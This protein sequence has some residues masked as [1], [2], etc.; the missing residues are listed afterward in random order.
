MNS[1]NTLVDLA[2]A[3]SA[4]G[5]GEASR[6]SYFEIVQLWNRTKSYRDRVLGVHGD[7]LHYI[8]NDGQQSCHPQ[9]PDLTKYSH[10]RLSGDI[11][12]LSGLTV[13]LPSTA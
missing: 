2:V 1:V 13:R 10:N 3:V 9:S 12:D 5:R 11:G 4:A 7:V 8:L 6:A